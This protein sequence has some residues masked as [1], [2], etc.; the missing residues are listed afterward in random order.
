MEIIDLN[1]IEEQMKNGLQI[2]EHELPDETEYKG[3]SPLLTEV[4]SNTQN[5]HSKVES[6]NWIHFWSEG[7]IH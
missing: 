5:T 1:K 2:E 7:R 4:M 6:E 3:G